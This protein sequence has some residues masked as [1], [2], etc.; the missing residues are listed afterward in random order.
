VSDLPPPPRI[1]DP[2]AAPVVAID[3]HLPAVPPE[4]LLAA[5]LRRRFAAAAAHIPELP[6]DGVRLRSGE[7]SNAAVL[8]GL[9]DRGAGLQVLLTRR[10]DHL[11]DHAGQISFPG[12]RSEPH[13]ADA[14]ATALREAHE[15]VG[16]AHDQAEV[17]GTLAPYITVTNYSVTPVIALLQPFAGLQLDPH[18]VADAFEVPLAFLMNPANHRWHQYDMAGRT[19]RF[20]SMPWTQQADAQ[21]LARE[22]FIWGATAA[23]LRNLYAALSA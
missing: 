1:I 23:I 16:L 12:G 14:A 7:L 11:R 13:D 4:R 5:A 10:T 19:R 3:A 22:H 8:I 2:Q 21:A 17:L 6:G 9:V 18:E 20:L 15:E